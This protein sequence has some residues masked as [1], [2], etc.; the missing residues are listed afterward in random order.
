MRA[1]SVGR[2]SVSRMTPKTAS[3]AAETS[4]M[5]REWRLNQS[6]VRVSLP[7]ARPTARNDSAETERVRDE[8]QRGVRDVL[9]SGR[10][11]EHRAEHG[12]DARR[13]PEPERDARHRCGH[14]TEAVEVRV[15]P[16]LLVQA[17]GREQ[18][19]PRE[20]ERHQEDETAGDAGER[21]LVAEERARRPRW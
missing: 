21:L 4:V 14:R 17:R 12:T 3:T 10:E 15:E 1:V 20:V 8:Q 7:I 2:E 11:A 19:R 16:E 18:L 5:A 13:P 9:A 6:R